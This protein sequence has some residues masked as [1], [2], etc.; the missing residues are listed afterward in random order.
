[1]MNSYGVEQGDLVILQ[2]IPQYENATIAGTLTT[3][4]FSPSV[5]TPDGV[6]DR[7]H[8]FQGEQSPCS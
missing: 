3:N 7:D 6:S 8:R 2:R 4:A 5:T 1:M